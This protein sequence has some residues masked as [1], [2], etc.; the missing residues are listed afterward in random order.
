M[1]K[2][3]DAC[4][5]TKRSRASKISNDESRE[6]KQFPY[7][8]ATQKRLALALFF[9]CFFLSFFLCEWSW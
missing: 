5:M 6:K 7:T 1:G 4:K 3:G 8:A 2:W 9:F